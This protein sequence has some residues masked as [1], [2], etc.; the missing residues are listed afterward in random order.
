M[1]VPEPAVVWVQVL[2]AIRKTILISVSVLCSTY[3]QSVLML[4]EVIFVSEELR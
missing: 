3:S 1:K 4:P 2:Q